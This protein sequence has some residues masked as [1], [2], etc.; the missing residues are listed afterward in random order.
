MV[1]LA[2]LIW[3]VIAVIFLCRLRQWDRRLDELVRAIE[4]DLEE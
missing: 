1:D 4:E 2:A 3:I